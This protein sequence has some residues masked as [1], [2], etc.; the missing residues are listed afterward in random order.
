M[1][2]VAGRT[3]AKASRLTSRI[4]NPYFLFT[5]PDLLR[6]C[7]NGTST[8]A[9]SIQGKSENDF[10]L[11]GRAARYPKPNKLPPGSSIGPPFPERHKV[12]SRA[13]CEVVQGL[14]RS[15]SQ[16]NII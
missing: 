7:M 10:I 9:P 14:S 1:T 15:H 5:V 8:S 4:W 6:R 3:K 12:A 16:G 11:F 2:A 13:R